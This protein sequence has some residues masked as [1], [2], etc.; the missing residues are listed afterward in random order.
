[1][2]KIILVAGPNGVGKT[3]FINTFLFKYDR[4]NGDDIAKS[5]GIQDTP[6]ANFLIREEYNKVVTTLFSMKKSFVIENNLESLI[7]SIFL[8]E[9]G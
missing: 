6:N 2:P 8:I 1:L 5:L 9:L 4:V 3:T 7:Q